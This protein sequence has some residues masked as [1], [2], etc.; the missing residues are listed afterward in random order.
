MTSSFTTDSN[1]C[2]QHW[3][4]QNVCCFHTFDG[5]V[6]TM[7]LPIIPPLYSKDTR[8]KDGLARKLLSTRVNNAECLTIAIKTQNANMF[9]RNDITF[10]HF[11]RWKLQ[12]PFKVLCVACYGSTPDELPCSMKVF[13]FLICPICLFELLSPCLYQNWNYKWK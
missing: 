2:T 6:I 8:G 10:L 4:R 5:L 9:C 7:S 12:K 1:T 13:F 11:S 3:D